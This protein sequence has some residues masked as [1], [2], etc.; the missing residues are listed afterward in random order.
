VE[1]LA[2]LALGTI[3]AGLAG[4]RLAHMLV[5]ERGVFNIFLGVRVLLKVEHDDGEPVSWPSGWLPQLFACTWCMSVWTCALMLSL[6]Y[7]AWIVGGWWLIGGIPIAILTASAIAILN[8]S[9]VK[10]V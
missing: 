3:A 7:M 6:Y 5:W 4:W 1:T 8:D 2:N 9:H 10:K